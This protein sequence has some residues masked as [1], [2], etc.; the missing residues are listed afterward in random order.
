MKK[1]L[2]FKSTTC[3]PCRMVSPIL[4]QVSKEM[5]VKLTEV[6]I[7]SDEG[8]NEAMM[9]GVSSVPTV[10]IMNDEDNVTHTFNG[11]RPK[12]DFVNALK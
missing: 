11:F 6:Y 1:I 9:Y 3:G 5:N 10:F 7:D 2:A 4:E 12:Q 8:V